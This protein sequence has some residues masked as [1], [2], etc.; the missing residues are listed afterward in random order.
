MIDVDLCLG[1]AAVFKEKLIDTSFLIGG[2]TIL[3]C[4]VQGNPFPRVFWYRNDE[5]IMEDDRIQF[6]QGEDGLC[7]LTITHCKAS[8]IGIYRCVARN[9]YGDASCKARLLIGG[10]FDVIETEEIRFF[11][12]FSSQMF[13]IDLNGLWSSIFHQRKR[14]SSGV[15]LS[16]METMKS[17]VSASI[18]K[19]AKISNGPIQ[20]SPSR[21]RH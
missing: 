14:I 6:A 10:Q 21:N 8:D 20:H 3:R 9:L 4:K 1:Y 5:F 15:H 13:L 19:L 7:T 17:T 2:T 11:L 18:T 16:T 12:L